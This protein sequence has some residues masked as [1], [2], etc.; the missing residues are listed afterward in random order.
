MFIVYGGEVNLATDEFRDPSKIEFVGAYVEYADA[1]KAWRG[2]TQRTVDIAVMRFY[3]A[4]FH[5]PITKLQLLE[6]VRKNCV[7]R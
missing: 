7:L 5:G 6:F 4:P 3:I 1:E 2:R